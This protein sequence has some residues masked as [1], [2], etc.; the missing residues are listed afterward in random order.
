MKEACVLWDLKNKF[1]LLLLLL[2]QQV[3]EHSRMWR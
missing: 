1:E 3:E 2:L